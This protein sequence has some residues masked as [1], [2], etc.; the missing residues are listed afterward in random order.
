LM[1]CATPLVGWLY[2][3]NLKLDLPLAGLMEMIRNAEEQA[4][5]LTKMFLRM[6]T[7]NDLLF[8]LLLIAI[9]PA[10]AEEFFFRG[11]VQK[12]VY[13]GT[14]N[15]HAAVWISAAIF[16]FMHFQFLG[17]LPR[18]FLGVVLGYLFA[19]S[20]SIW[21]SI[22]GHIFNNGSQVVAAYLFQRGLSGYDIEDNTPAP[23][24]V[25]LVSA[26]L[27]VALFYF[28]YKRRYVQAM[29]AAVSPDSHHSDPDDLPFV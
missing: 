4:T 18:M 29:P 19:Y 21:V 12:L 20:G 24:Y 3:L 5:V 14:R 22:V 9:L 26:L 13:E 28:M 23:V 7:F 1:V 17:F 16:S 10:I 27:T 11:V 15:V 2:Q 8:N 6:P 25:T